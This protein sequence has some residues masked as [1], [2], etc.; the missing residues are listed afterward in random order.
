MKNVFSGES[1][2]SKGANLEQVYATLLGGKIIGGI[3]DGGLD[4]LL[5]DNPDVPI[6]Q[7]KSSQEAAKVF[8][9]ESLRKM[10][11]I[12]IVVGDPGRFTKEE[13]L[14]SLSKNG[15]WAG[16][17]EIDREKFIDNVKK[18][19]DYIFSNGGNAKTI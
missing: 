2:E 4:V 12:P 9:K 8:L 13:I 18:T 3:G 15:A 19:R 5:E 14:E 10:E 11:F 7:V 17:D 16:F 1:V 6:L